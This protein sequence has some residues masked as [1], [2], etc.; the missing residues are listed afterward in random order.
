MIEIH[1]V[2][3]PVGAFNAVPAYYFKK[4][5]FL[6]Q[7]GI[8]NGRPSKELKIPK[9]GAKREKKIGCTAIDYRAHVDRKESPP[10]EIQFVPGPQ[11]V[12]GSDVCTKESVS[13]LAN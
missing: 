5:A 11:K 6:P 2:H 13:I 4:E 12:T 1:F 3:I 7:F 9:G 8:L 10:T